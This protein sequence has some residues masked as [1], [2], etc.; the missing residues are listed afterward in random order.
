MDSIR[1]NQR[2]AGISRRG[3]GGWDVDGWALV[4]ARRSPLSRLDIAAVTC[5]PDRVPHPSQLL[6][7]PYARP[8]AFTAKST[9]PQKRLS[10]F[11]LRFVNIKDRTCT[12]R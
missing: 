10:P 11:W 8:V 6:S 3:E 12:P 2:T 1:I 5:P 7:R 9:M 4:V